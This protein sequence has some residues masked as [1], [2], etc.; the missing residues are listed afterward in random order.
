MTVITAGSVHSLRYATCTQDGKDHIECEN[1]HQ[2]A[3]C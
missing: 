2:D 3:G 1:V